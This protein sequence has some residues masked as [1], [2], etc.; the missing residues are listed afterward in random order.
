MRKYL[1]SIGEIPSLAVRGLIR[2]YQLTLSGL[3]GRQCRHLPTCSS[4]A[5]EAIRRHGLWAGG[6]IGL[7]RL[8]RCRPLGTSGYD[9]VPEVLPSAGA[10]HR[11]W[12]WALWSARGQLRA[13]SA[14]NRDSNRSRA[15]SGSDRSD[16]K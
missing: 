5:D 4:F 1:I 15:A 9:P 3:A 12:A 16:S 6:W 7:G 2:L 13:A 11:P 14:V 10:W 8:S